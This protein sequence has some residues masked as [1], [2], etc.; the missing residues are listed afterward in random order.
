MVRLVAQQVEASIRDPWTRAYASEVIKGHT[1]LAV[2]GGPSEEDQIGKIFWHIKH[3]VSYLQDPRGYEFIATVKHTIRI[4]SGDC[5]DA[6]VAVAS[7]LGSIGFATGARVISPDNSNWHIYA[8]CMYD[9]MYKPS[10]YIVL[11]TT[12][13][14]SY[15]GWEPPPMMRRHQI[16][17]TFAN[18]K[19]Y[20]SNGREL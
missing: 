12:Q 8:V 3:N 10:R 19:A 5:D 20:L 15:P 9:P 16:D 17:V 13:K 11:D 4:G 14:D 2:A 6:T 7:L 18:G 1:Q